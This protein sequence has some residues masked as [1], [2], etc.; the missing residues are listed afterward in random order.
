MSGNDSIRLIAM[1]LLVARRGCQGRFLE[2]KNFGGVSKCP[3][4]SLNE[5]P[6][7]SQREQP[8]RKCKSKKQSVVLTIANP[9]KSV[10]SAAFG[11]CASTLVHLPVASSIDSSSECSSDTLISCSPVFTDTCLTDSLLR[12]DSDTSGVGDISPPELALP[13]SVSGN[14][15]V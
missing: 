14:P 9:A 7:M 11:S 1:V 4:V 10:E 3:V 6:V 15:I 13:G 2:E 5:T 12:Y 8:W